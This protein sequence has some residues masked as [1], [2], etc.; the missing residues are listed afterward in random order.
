MN[1]V[2]GTCVKTNVNDCKVSVNGVPLD[3][4]DQRLLRHGDYILIRIAPS[5][6]TDGRVRLRQA[7]GILED[8]R[9]P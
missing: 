3:L 2:C 7:F 5:R 4:R 9:R 1:W 6:G 8:F